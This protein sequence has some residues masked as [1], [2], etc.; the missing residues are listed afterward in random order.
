[1][2]TNRLAVVDYPC[3]QVFMRFGGKK[4]PPFYR[5]FLAKFHQE[6]MLDS[7]NTVVGSSSFLSQS[8]LLNFVPN[9]VIITS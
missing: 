9:G 7:I 5:I 8:E 3:I 4:I 6:T 2:V 1:M